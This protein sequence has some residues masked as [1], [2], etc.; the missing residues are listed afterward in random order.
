MFLM[1]MAQQTE[2]NQLNDVASSP[3][4]PAHHSGSGATPVRRMPWRLLLQVTGESQLTIGID[5]KDI[6]LLGRADANAKVR[7]D[8][9]LMPYGA[10]NLGVSR[11]H[12][13]IIRQGQALFI[14]DLRSTN[15]TRLNGFTLRP[16][17]RYRLKDGDELLLG[18]LRIV[19]RFVKAPSS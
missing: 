7:P 11:R 13:Q 6:I 14:E 10:S 2:T 19:L 8:V 3:Q 1:A 9:D 12:A 18:N 4:M 5:V 17:Q 15:Q 16:E